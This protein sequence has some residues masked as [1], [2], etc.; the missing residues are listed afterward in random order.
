MGLKSALKSLLKVLPKQTRLYFEQDLRWMRQKNQAKPYLGEGR[1]C[2]CCGM[3][4][5]EFVPAGKPERPGEMCLRCGGGRRQRLM[6]HFLTSQLKQRPRTRL[7]HFAPEVS[8]TRVITRLPNIEY[9]SIDIA[10][11]VA[12][13]QGDIQN[14]PFAGN[15]FDVIV[16]SHVLEH[17]P[18]DA[19]AMGELRRVLTGDG[20]AY[21]MVPQDFERATTYEDPTITDP[22]GR[23]RAFGQDD[24]VRMYGRDF[25]DRLTKA[26]FN[27]E[28]R[29][30]KEIAD[31]QAIRLGDLWD[32]VIYVCRPT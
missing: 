19:K 6:A 26:G 9:Q 29:R 7:L 32:D 21:V 10:E 31:E 24:H 28:T 8:L 4:W 20:V 18:D 2:A 5:R 23:E 16:C 12:L 22:A 13:T 1:V 15:T 3:H 14:L 25:V 27:V 17:I 30:T 11:D